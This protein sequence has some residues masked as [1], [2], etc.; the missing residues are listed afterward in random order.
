MSADFNTEITIKA[1]KEDLIKLIKGLYDFK[2]HSKKVNKNNY[3]YLEWIVVKCK[4]LSL[5]VGKDSTIKK[6]VTD[7]GEEI[8]ISA[9]GPYGYFYELSEV[10]LFEY[11]AEIAPRAYFKGSINGFSGTADQN[12]QAELKDSR[13][14]IEKSYLDQ[15]DIEEDGAHAQY[16]RFIKKELPYS[17]FCKLFKIDKEEFDEDE[18]NEV[19]YDMLL[20]YDSLHELDYETFTEYDLSDIEEDEFCVA[21]D[22]ISNLKLLSFDEFM[23][24][25]YFDE[26]CGTAT[27]I[28]DPIKKE[29]LEEFENEED[30]F[31]EDYEEDEE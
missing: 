23:S 4:N 31:E 21:M 1:T 6:F 11:L 14:Y 25:G 13:L 29:Y 22:K 8:N 24:E 26:Y 5:Y 16:V 28:Y 27:I 10:K 3:A 15:G 19:I 17:K 9:S 12:L 20:A 7:C 30:D 18:Y 2:K